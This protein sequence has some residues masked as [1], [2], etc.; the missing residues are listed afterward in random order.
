VLTTTVG[1]RAVV[2]RRQGPADATRVILVV[3][4]MHGS[5]RD[6]PR[7]VTALRRATAPEGVQ[8]W[9]IATMNPDGR[10]VGSRYNARGVDLNRNFPVNWDTRLNNEGPRPASERETRAMLDFVS[11]LSPDAVL[12]YH[13]PFGLI[14]VTGDKTRP[15]A[16][17]LARWIGLRP[18][19]ASCVTVCGG[20][21]TGWIN[22]TLPGWAITVELPPVVDEELIRRNVDA[23][24]RVSTLVDD[25]ALPVPDQPTPDQPTTSQ[26]TLP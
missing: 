11:L 16:K 1:G 12:S 24:L 13:Q 9:T 2:A 3:G 14:D 15:W 20:T 18:G 25:V 5:E 10:A 6:T 21:M 22:A 4:Q 23:I 26:V 17:R 7:V 19:V 8:L